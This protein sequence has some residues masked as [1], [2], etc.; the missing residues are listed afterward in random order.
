MT[1]DEKQTNQTW[2]KREEVMW[3]GL[4]DPSWMTMQMMESCGRRARRKWRRATK[5]AE[6]SMLDRDRIH[7]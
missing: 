2:A 4:K 6:M 1:W 7:A 5:K 3:K